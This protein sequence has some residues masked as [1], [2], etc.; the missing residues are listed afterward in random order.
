METQVHG[1]IK[2]TWKPLRREGISAT[3]VGSQVLLCSADQEAIHFLNP[4][5]RLIWE[6]CDGEHTIEDLARAIGESF[7]V[8]EAVDLRADV[9]ATLATLVTKELLHPMT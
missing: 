4:T 1:P 5:A 8:P 2:L 9:E 3:E 7:N 6:L